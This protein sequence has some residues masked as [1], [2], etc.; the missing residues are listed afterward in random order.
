MKKL[1]SVMICLFSLA[2]LASCGRS[3]LDMD[4][5]TEGNISQASIYGWGKSVVLSSPEELSSLVET[6]QS[7]E[8]IPGG[9]PDEPGAS[10]VTVTLV[11]SDGEVSI[12][13]PVF[14]YGGKAWSADGDCLQIFSQYLQ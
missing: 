4:A 5:L 14:S 6:I 9:N 3:E 12:T 1:M 8:F 11:K 2:L 10:S 7:I 13:Y